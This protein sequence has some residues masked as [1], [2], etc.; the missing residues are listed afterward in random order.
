MGRLYIGN[1]KYTP[2]VMYSKEPVKNQNITVTENGTYVCEDNYTG[3]GTVSVNVQHTPN[4]QNIT[5]TEN[6]TYRCDSSYDGLGDVTV[7][8]NNPE[9][10]YVNVNICQTYW[11]NGIADMTDA[12]GIG[13]I[14]VNQKLPGI[15]FRK[16]SS[17]YIIAK[18]K[19]AQRY[20]NK[21]RFIFKSGGFEI[22]L[23]PVSNSTYKLKLNIAYTHSSPISVTADRVLEKDHNY[24]ISFRDVTLN[25]VSGFGLTLRDGAMQTE[26]LFVIPYENFPDDEVLNNDDYFSFGWDF[27]MEPH[28]SG[29]SRKLIPGYIDLIRTTI[30]YFYDYSSIHSPYKSFMWFGSNPSLININSHGGI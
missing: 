23:V 28:Q 15:N 11:E 21:E 12:Y 3:L 13:A 2:V 16:V 27:I 8:V 30:Q 20:S 6:G 19:F 29:H 17:F 9:S 18:M 14:K 24:E 25:N 4:N 26:T 1:K 5:V 10:P 7:A 22:K